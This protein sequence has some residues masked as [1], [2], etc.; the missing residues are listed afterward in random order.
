MTSSTNA[1]LM[2]NHTYQWATK[3]LNDRKAKW[4]ESSRVNILVK[5]IFEKRGTCHYM[6][7]NFV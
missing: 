1:K 4:E 6:Y 5:T 7:F 2:P 3:V